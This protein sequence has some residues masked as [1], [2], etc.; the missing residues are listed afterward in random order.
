MLKLTA[1]ILATVATA[2]YKPLKWTDCSDSQSLAQVWGV[3][4][5]PEPQYLGEPWTIH[6]VLLPLIDFTQDLAIRMHVEAKLYE[7]PVHTEDL[8]VCNT[9]NPIALE[10]GLGKCPYTAGVPF[11]FH[12]TNTI[13]AFDPF[14]GPYES[15]VWLTSPAFPNQKLACFAW[16]MTYAGRNVSVS[17]GKK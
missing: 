14:L 13:P 9:T 6:A 12:D 15:S 16:D 4:I 5:T 1:I 2:D 11:E 3:S 17:I 8:W 10:D 7:I